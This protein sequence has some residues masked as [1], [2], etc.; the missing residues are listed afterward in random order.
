MDRNEQANGDA[1]TQYR[2]L[3]VDDHEIV[4]RGLRAV[5]QERAEIAVVGE[6]GTVQSG[7][8]EAARLQPDIVVMDLR[9]PDGSGVEAC[10]EIRSQSPDTKVIILTSYADEDALFAAVMAGAS[11]Y[12][13]KDLDPDRLQEAIVTV[14]RGGSLL[15][16]KLATAVLERL[17]RGGAQHPADDKFSTLSP[18][19]DRILGYIGEGLTNREIAELLNLSEKT[20]KNYVSQIYAKLH[21]KRRS[22]AATIATERRLRKH[23]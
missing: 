4:R 6:A 13:L 12:V 23:E 3:L 9:L 2:V 18:Q 21:I 19:E 1:E 20:I 16:P 14:G 10:R 7:I 11:G 8:E 22:Q 15:D 17:R 5:L